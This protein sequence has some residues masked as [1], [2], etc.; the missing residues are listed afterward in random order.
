MPG[1]LLFLSQALLDAWTERERVE[2]SVDAVTLR[3]GGG[4]VR[5]YALVPAVR[6]LRVTGGGGD[7]HGLVA[8]VK[9]T[10]QLRSLG[11]EALGGSVVMGEVA[12]EVEAGYLAEAAAVRAA[13]AVRPGFAPPAR[14]A[15]T[16]AAAGSGAG[17]DREERRREADALARFL[18][19]NLP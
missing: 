15:G 4:E 7:P 11:A 10:A 13:S 3:G 18:L 14:V 8:R 16:S 9:T 12:Y 19:D 5:R 6:F 17:S 2:V 1:G